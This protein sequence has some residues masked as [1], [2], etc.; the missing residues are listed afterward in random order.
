[1]FIRLGWRVINLDHVRYILETPQE[2]K[3]GKTGAKKTISSLQIHT[4]A[5]GEPFELLEEESEALRQYLA[6]MPDMI[7]VIPYVPP[8]GG[9]EK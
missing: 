6:H 7:T 9:S 2:V 1:M 4:T 8:A 5:P 3:D